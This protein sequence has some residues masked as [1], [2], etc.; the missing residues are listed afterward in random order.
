MSQASD[1]RLID[2]EKENSQLR[3]QLEYNES[4]LLRL[5]QET[6]TSQILSQLLDA[7]LPCGANLMQESLTHE[8]LQSLQCITQS[9]QVLIYRFNPVSAEF[10]RIDSSRD[11]PRGNSLYFTEI[12]R[13]FHHLDE[14][15]NSQCAGVLEQHTGL[16]FFHWYYDAKSNLALLCAQS[17]ATNSTFCQLNSQ[18]L[19]TALKLYQ[20]TQIRSEYEQRLHERSTLDSLT[21]LPN[22]SVAFDRLGQ[23]ILNRSNED[24][25]VFALYVDIA[26]FRDIN[27]SLGHK[28]GDEILK[29]V[30]Q[31]IKNSVRESDTVACLGGDEFLVI[32]ENANKLKAAQVVACKVIDAVT[33]PVIHADKEIRLNSNIGIAAYPGDGDET[34]SLIR[35]ADTAMYES[36]RMGLNKYRFYTQEMNQ[37]IAERIS[38]ERNL[39]R[40]INGDE[41]E[42]YFQPLLDCNN[43]EVCGAEALIR[44][45]NPELGQV[46]PERFIPVAEEDGLIIPIGLW[47]M[48]Q[49]CK[50]LARW[51]SLGY[52]QLHVAVN[53]SVRQLMDDNFLEHT[54][55]VC[56]KYGIA[57]AMLQLEVTEGLLLTNKHGE[58]EKLELLHKAGFKIAIDDFG[59]GYASLS[60]L[61]RFDFDYLKID[62]SFILSMN[63]SHHD[64]TIVE[65]M[66]A[67][68]HKLG[69]KVIAEGVEN[70]QILQ[71]LSEQSCDL[72]QGYHISRPLAASDFEDF[73]LNQQQ[74]SQSP[75]FM[76]ALPA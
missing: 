34:S 75:A 35:N 1:S 71:H 36:R 38:L 25:L 46:S 18:V 12:P 19:A 39:H 48:E 37:E 32:L 51:R 17:E 9:K 62:R 73:L 58:L 63:K 43:Q 76:D 53:V 28:A 33:M 6:A 24:K 50:N 66:L 8:Y 42:L 40:A 31:R 45:R 57:P 4:R 10:E 54:L 47:V 44:W 52:R 16:R 13:L 70:A 74:E 72:A 20:D 14:T 68:G 3:Q 49:A 61:S 23:A 29:Q 26:R 11:T 67:M 69:M 55:N 5:K 22:R 56:N 64:Q 60:Y 27:E 65:A 30:A 15:Q 7:S 59:T 2:L 21:G 41:F